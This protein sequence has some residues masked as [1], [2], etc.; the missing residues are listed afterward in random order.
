MS[1]KI[2]MTCWNFEGRFS[3]STSSSS[4]KWLRSGSRYS[5]MSSHSSLAAAT[6]AFSRVRVGAYDDVCSSS[7]WCMRSTSG[8]A[9]CSDMNS[10]FFFLAAQKSSS[11]SGI[12]FP[13]S[14][15][16]CAESCLRTFNTWC[17]QSITADS[18]ICSSA[19]SAPLSALRPSVAGSGSRV[20][21]AIW[22]ETTAA[23]VLRRC[24]WCEMSAVTTPGQASVLLSS[25]TD[26]SKTSST[27]ADSASITAYDMSPRCSLP[28]FS[29]VTAI[30]CG[31]MK[32]TAF[33]LLTEGNLSKGSI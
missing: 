24:S 26:G 1:D 30:S 22:P 21:P 20:L 16:G 28:M 23:D 10:R 31:L 29:F 33:P 32:Y 3:N 7:T 9:S 11:T 27:I 4:S 25:Q 14:I 12:G 8:E 18:Y 19:C 6:S 15:N 5:V 2:C 17:V 13:P